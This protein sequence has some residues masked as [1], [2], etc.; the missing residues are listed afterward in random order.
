MITWLDPG[1]V[2]QSPVSVTN[3][4]FVSSL[5][6]RRTKKKRKQ[7]GKGQNI[8][9]QIPTK[10]SPHKALLIHDDYAYYL[11]FDGKWLAKSIYDMSMVWN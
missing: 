10:I 1:G 3:W 9:S 11:W 6:P 8:Q 7:K 4:I 2:K 5:V